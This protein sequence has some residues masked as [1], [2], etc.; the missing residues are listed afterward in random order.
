MTPLAE[1][2]AGAAP[3]PV[4]WHP[5]AESMAVE[6]PV[7]TRETTMCAPVNI[8]RQLEGVLRE[9][10]DGAGEGK[11]TKRGLSGAAAASDA[12]RSKKVAFLG[13][14]IIIVPALA[15]SL[16][17]M[18]NVR[19]FL[20]EGRYVSPQQ[21]QAEA[22]AAGGTGEKPSMLTV[23]HKDSRGVLCE[24]KVVDNPCKL[25][26]AGW[27]RVAAVFV[28]GPKWQFTGWNW[29]RPERGDMSPPEIFRRCL[30]CHL[31]FVDDPYHENIPKWS[32]RLL[33]L[34][35]ARRHMDAVTAG[36]FWRDLDEF[37]QAKKPGLLAPS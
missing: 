17:N 12:K 34:D 25:G 31:H 16:I 11:G 23:Q 1:P 19:Q 37:L 8:R 29:A 30:A 2:D 36:K 35:R 6:V 20:E 13:T 7:R 26:R 27:L 9:L 10:A 33:N 32:L 24:Y 21:A 14:P 5:L 15:S 22:V 28:L 18:H 4:G 3:G